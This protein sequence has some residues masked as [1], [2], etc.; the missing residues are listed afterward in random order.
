M[1]ASWRGHSEVARE[2]LASGTDVNA[3]R[4]DGLVALHMAQDKDH[5]EIVQ[6][7]QQAGANEV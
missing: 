3:E 1:Y 5:T 7:L 2:L 4:E 6:L